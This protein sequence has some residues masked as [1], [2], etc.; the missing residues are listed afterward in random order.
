MFWVLKR[1]ISMRFN[2]LDKKIMTIL[3]TKSFAFSAPMKTIFL[4]SV[5]QDGFAPP[6]EDDLVDNEEDEY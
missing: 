6:D 4:F 5:L 1:T 2:L 3:R